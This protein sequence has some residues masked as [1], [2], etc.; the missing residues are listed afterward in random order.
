M[1]TLMPIISI[2]FMA[3]FTQKQRINL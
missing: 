2:E 3:L 1:S